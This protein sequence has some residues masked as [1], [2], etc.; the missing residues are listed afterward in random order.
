MSVFIPPVGGAC[1]PVRQHLH[2]VYGWRSR[3]DAEARTP[4]R[5]YGIMRSDREELSADEGA[6][7]VA[8]YLPISKVSGHI[9]LIP[10]GEAALKALQGGVGSPLSC[11]WWPPLR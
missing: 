3:P 6:R 10:N 8:R 2:D 11:S 4:C 1:K 5:A 9:C 7:T